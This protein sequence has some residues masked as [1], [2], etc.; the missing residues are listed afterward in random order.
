M[1]KR[2]HPPFQKGSAL[3]RELGRKGGSRP[4]KQHRSAVGLFTGTVFDVMDW[5]G[6]TGPTWE[7]W[8][9]VLR[10]SFGLPH[11]GQ[12]L[13]FFRD[14]TGRETP[15]MT[16]VS[17][18]W[19]VA[20][21]R[22][23]KSRMAAVVGLTKALQFDPARLAPGELG[24]VPII[25]ADR[26]QS[27]AVFSY[28]RALCLLPQVRPFVHRVLKETI[29]L[30]G[31]INVEVHTASY[32]TIRGYTVI[33]AILDEVAFWRD[34]S[35]SSNPDSEILDA[36]R[37][38]MSTVPDA[39]LFAISSPYARKGEL[40]TTYDRYFGSDNSQ[41]LVWNADTRT[42]NPSVAAHVIMRAFAED[43]VAAASE[44]GQDGQ[45]V[46]RRDV[47]A[48]LDPEAIHAV[49]VS[50]RRE[51]P[52]QSG[53]RYVGF[54]DPSGGSQ[55]SFTVAIAHREG[56]RAVLDALRETRPPFS[57][58]AVVQ[59]FAELLKRYGITTVTGDR[60]GG[61]WPR[62]AFRSHGIRYEPS[63]RV[64]SDLYRELV[65]PVNAGRVEL[66][67]LPALRAQ[68]V[69]LER[70][71]AR[72][73]KDSIDHAPGG[74]DDLSNAAAGALVL[75]LPAVLGKYRAKCSFGDG[76]SIGFD[77]PTAPV[78]TE[79][80]ERE[81]LATQQMAAAVTAAKKRAESQAER[82]WERERQDDAAPMVGE[83]TWHKH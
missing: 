16:P 50:D 5:G 55:D 22:G 36:L 39:L 14:H 25:A 79:R 11:S 30:A 82:A 57:P 72:G 34:E 45:V 47:E 81:R 51:L 3:A 28:L 37:P 4:K 53:V 74:R 17:E 19:V 71:V 46:F 8:R 38:G 31:G 69:G 83:A 41:V 7:P 35:T 29:E 76:R 18:C 33:A 32:R 20:G 49:T 15:T 13:V 59:D 48:F 43:P 58:D 77:Q 40:F 78:R 26:K 2:P 12:D 68:L 64:K 65:A 63:E 60:Y 23:G 70:R 73:G 61:E 1:S 67:D 9:A 42:L 6:M 80:Q 10:T 27:R 21:R 66:L 24:V 56:D 75:V 44:Y 54:V 52:P 62:E